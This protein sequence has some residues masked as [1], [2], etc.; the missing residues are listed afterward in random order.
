MPSQLKP[1]LPDSC[2]ISPQLPQQATDDQARYP[3]LLPALSKY[4][5]HWLTLMGVHQEADLPTVA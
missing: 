3:L 1:P 4:P 2:R 5:G